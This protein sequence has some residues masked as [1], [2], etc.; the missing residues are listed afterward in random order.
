MTDTLIEGFKTFKQNT[1]KGSD[2]LMPSLIKEGQNPKYF[3]ISCIDSRSNPGTIFNTPPGA[4]FAH[5]AMGAIVRPYK[6]GTGLSAALHFALNYNEVDTV[7]IMGHTQC[8]AVQALAEKLDDD[9]ISSFINVA[10]NALKRAEAC[11][12][13]HSEVLARTEKE[14]VLESLNNIKEYPSV[15]NALAEKRVTVKGW[16][17]D[18]K[19][20]AILEYKDASETFENISG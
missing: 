4:F 3:I 8:G 11:C 2:P 20:A 9:E 18:M 14:V 12:S 1:Y 5:K 15:A 13:E 7:I 10:K 17:F 19:E 6:Q 16:V